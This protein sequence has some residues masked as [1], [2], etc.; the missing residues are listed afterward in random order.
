MCGNKENCCMAEVHGNK[1]RF[2]RES[3][4][5]R[6]VRQ[7]KQVQICSEQPSFIVLR[8]MQILWG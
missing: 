7:F 1:D 8:R 2:V 5:S 6:A 4:L 3:F